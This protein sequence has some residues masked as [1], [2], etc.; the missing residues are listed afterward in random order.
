MSKPLS[1]IGALALVFAL[2]APIAVRAEIVS[3]PSADPP[4]AAATPPTPTVLRGSPS[5]TAK[6]APFCPPGYTLSP[7]YGCI[8]PSGGDYAD[9]SQG[10]DYW[11][12]Y[13]WGY[14]FGGL[15]AFGAGAGRFHHVARSHGFRGLPGRA[16]FRGRAGFHAPAGFHAQARFGGFA[17]G[18][19]HTGGGFGHR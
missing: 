8:A 16:G 6:A 10:Y 4:D 18:A 14:P 3:V 19:G 5:S 1:V 11:P 13:G 2:I 17:A 7:G 15:P 9:G 12:D